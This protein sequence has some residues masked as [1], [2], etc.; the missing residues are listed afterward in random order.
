MPGR[1]WIRAKRSSRRHCSPMCR[2]PSISAASSSERASHSAP[3]RRFRDELEDHMSPDYRGGDA[4]HHD[5]S[6]GRYAELFAY[7]EDADMFSLDNPS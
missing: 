5:S 3:A 4:R 6:R 7:D 1:M 2:S